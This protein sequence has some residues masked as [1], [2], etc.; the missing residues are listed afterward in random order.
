MGVAESFPPAPTLEWILNESNRILNTA[1]TIVSVTSEMV[2]NHITDLAGRAESQVN[3]VFR[4]IEDFLTELSGYGEQAQHCISQKRSEL[5]KARDDLIQ[6]LVNC[7]K[8]RQKVF[9]RL[10]SERTVLHDEAIKLKQDAEVNL[11]RCT[12]ESNRN[13]EVLNQ[14][15]TRLSKRVN[16]LV[17]KAEVHS[18]KEFSERREN[19]IKMMACDRKAVDQAYKTI[20]KIIKDIKDCMFTKINNPESFYSVK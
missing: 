2:M 19:I 8:V 9:E 10:K 20:R 6:N 1:A 16:T 11:A 17:K 7:Y 5:Q 4:D 12:E 3:M 18:K 15:L 13:C 14:N